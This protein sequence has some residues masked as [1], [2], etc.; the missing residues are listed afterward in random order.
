MNNRIWKRAKSFV[1]AVILAGEI[2][3]GG[4]AGTVR[5]DEKEKTEEGTKENTEENVKENTGILLEQEA[6]WTDSE[7]YR[8]LIT[9]RIRGLKAWSAGKETA[10]TRNPEQEND[11][12]G[13]LEEKPEEKPKERPEEK[14]EE[15]REGEEEP[16]EEPE[17]VPDQVQDM[18]K[19]SDGTPKESPQK[20]QAEVPETDPETDRTGTGDGI[21]E[22]DGFQGA[23]RDTTL[24][25][26]YDNENKETTA[27]QEEW[28]GSPTEDIREETKSF[29]DMERDSV[30]AEQWVPEIGEPPFLPEG[31]ELP[32]IEYDVVPV[33]A[34]IPLARHV[35][36]VQEG[37][38]AEVI[39][40]NEKDEEIFLINMISP[41]FSVETEK[42]RED[43]TAEE[44]SVVNQ[45]GEEELLTSVT[46]SVDVHNGEGETGA[47]TDSPSAG[48]EPG[49]QDE[50]IVEIPVI[51]RDAWRLREEDGVYPVCYNEIPG[52][53]GAEGGVCLITREGG[54]ETILAD[55]PSGVLRV[56]GVK[57]SLE[58]ALSDGG[59]TP[60]AGK[61]FRYEVILKNT[62]NVPLKEICLESVF[63]P[64][65][66]KGVWEP[67]EGLTVE[68]SG[69]AI[70]KEL[71]KGESRSLGV[72]MRLP[73]SFKGELSHIVS[74][75][76]TDAADS[77]KEI[78]QEV[79]VISSIL[80]L[81]VDYSVKKTAD[82]I[83]AYPGDTIIYQICIR[84]TGERTLHSVL[85]TERFVKK[86]I[87]ARFREQE[88]VILSED[89]TQALIP[90]ISPGEVYSMEASVTLPQDL[91]SGELI[92][93]VIVMTRETG[94][95]IVQAESGITVEPA[96]AP[97]VTELP[98][99]GSIP[100]DSGG[101][102]EFSEPVFD[103]P[104]TGDPS[105]TE[106]WMG[107]MGL[108]LLLG[109]SAVLLGNC[110]KRRKRKD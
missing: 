58:L 43:T 53:P 109:I 5:A 33:A 18:G 29:T 7:N 87:S 1:L 106:F 22:N 90:Q 77:Q 88:G 48:G 67:A 55:A 91:E 47:S 69:R 28:D 63:F 105:R 11:R 40:G 24:E 3:A 81:K 15:N 51:L 99:K 97:L 54:K 39:S 72:G 35:E 80:P 101:L 12:K 2:V 49:E 30:Q 68:T 70:L 71:K 37:A 52:L 65:E 34:F 82:R 9:V 8:A 42:L 73:E 13:N 61:D 102:E 41:F 32:Q 76:T 93:Q 86:N 94:N 84:N 21:P 46:T 60:V 23:M 92:N 100:V 103:N 79:A 38:L 45:D 83:Q 98:V 27:A 44:I 10:D 96:Q 50:Y 104:K 57:S 89:R 25:N 107:L 56:E 26:E 20:D 85:S 36:T 110:L 4:S 74:A 31:T 6:R 108:A 19:V 16:G 95:R 64:E 66:I 78:R 62:G 14:S 75:A 59:R 17:V